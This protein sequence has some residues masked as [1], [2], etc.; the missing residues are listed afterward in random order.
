VVN[1]GVAGVAVFL[2]RGNDRFSTP[3]ESYFADPAGVVQSVAVGDVNG[4]GKLDIVAANGTS[5]DVT[6]L[7]G[8]GDG[9]FKGATVSGTGVAAPNFPVGNNPVFV[10]LADVNGD[11]KL[12]IVTANYADGT[13]SVLLGHGDGTFRQQLTFAA[14]KGPDHIA[15][16]DVDGDGTLD[17]LVLDAVRDSVIVMSGYKDGVFQVVTTH[18]LGLGQQ[19]GESQS[20]VVGDFNHDGHPDLAVTLTGV[21]TRSITVLLGDGKGGFDDP[22]THYHVGL[23]PHFITTADVDQDGNLDLLVADGEGSTLSVLLGKGDGTF[24]TVQTFATNGLAGANPLQSLA[25]G[26]FDGDAFPDVVFPFVSEQAIRLLKNDGQGGF[27]PLN[28]YLTGRTPVAVSTAD[29]NGD[30]HADVVLADSGDD[31]VAVFLGN[32]NGTLQAPVKYAT[33]ANPQALSLVDVNGDG[34]TDIVTANFGDGTVSVL[35]GNGD[36][37]FQ[38]RQDFAAGT[39]LLAMTVADMDGDGKPDIVVGYGITNR[40]GILY[41]RGDGT[42]RAPLTHH[43]GVILDAIAVGDVNGD[44]HPDIVVAGSA[45]S[46][47]INNGQGGFQPGARFV[48]HGFRVYL[49]DLNHDGHLDALL[50]DYNNSSLDVLL[51]NGDGTFQA[52]LPYATS[53]SPLG[54]TLADVNGDGVLDAVVAASNDASVAIMLGNDRGGFLGVSYPAEFGPR[55]TA[56]ADFDED[57]TQDVAV[58]NATS[59][60]LNLILQHHGVVA[61]D[62]APAVASGTVQVPDGKNLGLGL[63]TATD[64]D[65]GDRLIYGLITPAAN[66]TVDINPLTGA[67]TYLANPRFTGLDTFEYQ[68]TD[69]MKLSNRAVV[70]IS[71]LTNSTGKSGGGGGF[72]FLPLLC[73]L[74]LCSRRSFAS[75]H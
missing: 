26:N 69:S 4:D 10:A 75:K 32:G 23:Q 17:L 57:G 66:G 21:A 48:A 59:N 70:R 3:T 58:V 16:A 33:G 25:V 12:D 52:P 18:S 6:V 29:L 63:L 61:A 53:A 46:V 27:H 2:G 42:F 55:A 62:H 34:K 74:F 13:V 45:V 40:V 11:G 67:F 71:V 31:D 64:K 39:N 56:V 49:A 14:G 54:V 50:S 22:G 24:R 28:T 7:L 35:L 51:G 8:N 20:F 36:G 68:V 47:L 5:N 19:N 15:F 43:A 65:R 73:L 41:G 9:T 37:T 1:Q 44:G 30:H 38:P 60:T 72:G